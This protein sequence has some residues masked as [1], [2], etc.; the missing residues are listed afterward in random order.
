MTF[1][2]HIDILI[3]KKSSVLS[4]LPLS[5]HSLAYDMQ[6]TIIHFSFEIHEPADIWASKQSDMDKSYAACTLILS[7]ELSSFLL[8]KAPQVSDTFFQFIGEIFRKF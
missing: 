7:R 6:K 5:S 2:H 4:R 3:I 8:F 1:E